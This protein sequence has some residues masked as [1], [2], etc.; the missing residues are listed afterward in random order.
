MR[1]STA[2]EIRRDAEANV[3][4]KLP[5][6]PYSVVFNPLEYDPLEVNSPTPVMATIADDLSDTYRDLMEGL[7]L[8]RA[9]QIQSALW[10]WHFTYYTHWGRHVS[11]AQSAIWQYLS[12]GNWD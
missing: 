1:K 6:D 11:H 5:V 2:S 10:H 8:H 9:D 12:E 3:R 7:V 4:K